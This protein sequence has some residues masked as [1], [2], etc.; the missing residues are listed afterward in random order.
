MHA[1]IHSAAVSGY[2]VSQSQERSQHGGDAI[3]RER[4]GPALHEIDSLFGETVL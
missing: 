4:S 1:C 3:D 2:L